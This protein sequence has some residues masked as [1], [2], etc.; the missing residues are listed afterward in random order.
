MVHGSVGAVHAEV[1]TLLP[2]ITGN[3]SYGHFGTDPCT[4][5]LQPQTNVLDEPNR[6]GYPFPSPHHPRTGSNRL[7]RSPLCSDRR[8]YRSP[9]FF[10]HIS[11]RV[12]GRKVDRGSTGCEAVVDIET[13]AVLPV[14]VSPPGRGTAPVR[15]YTIPRVGTDPPRE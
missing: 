6:Q 8:R 1:H 5:L 3:K 10:S 13:G 11:V 2:Y 14:E 9:P 12:T 4:V 7:F 15:L